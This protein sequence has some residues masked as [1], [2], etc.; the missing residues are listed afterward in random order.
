LAGTN[1]TQE[2]G[3]RGFEETNIRPSFPLINIDGFAQFRGSGF[4]NRPKSNRIRT[5]QY[6]DNLSYTDGRHDLKMGLE[7]YHQMHGLVIGGGAE[8]KFTFR[9]T[10]SGNAFADFLLGYP[11]NVFRNYFQNLFGNW[12]DFKHFYV[13]DNYRITPDLTLNLGLRWEIN[14]FFHGIR[15]QTTGF[16]FTTGKVVVPSNLDLTAQP[17]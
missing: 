4:D 9:N 1:F 14:P 3:I 10:Y 15:A 13:Q 16:D 8:G 17:Q 6:A 7:W 2:A 12:D 11:D 5:W